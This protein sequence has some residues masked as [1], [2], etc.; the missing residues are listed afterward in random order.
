[1]RAI[2]SA[3][4]AMLETATAPMLR[5]RASLRQELAYLEKLVRQMAQD[6]PICVRPM[7]MPGVGAVVALTYQSA[8]RR[9][10]SIHLVEERW[11]VGRPDAV[12][13]P[14]RRA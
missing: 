3:R 11:P 6:D 10:C 12:A 13:Q 7:T 4:N 14:V 2:L 8:G 5:A 1:M 9:P